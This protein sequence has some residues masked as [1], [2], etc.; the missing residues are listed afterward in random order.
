MSFWVNT[1]SVLGSIASV[2]AAIWAFI[3]ARKSMAAASKAETIK[4]EM[5]DRRQL[6]EA[7]KIHSETE[8]VISK[9]SQ[10]GPASR[11]AVLSGI[12]IDDILNEVQGYSTFIIAQSEQYDDKFKRAVK[13]LNTDLQANIAELSKSTLEEDYKRIGTQIFNALQGFLPTAKSLADGRRENVQI[14]KDGYK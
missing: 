8:R 6:V 9:V 10:I 12:N 5:I 3:E 2:G 7:S 4:N 13:K 11:V 1:I 14:Q